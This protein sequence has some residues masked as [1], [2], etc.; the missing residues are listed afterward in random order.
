MTGLCTSDRLAYKNRAFSP[1]KEKEF[2][3]EKNSF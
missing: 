3:V 2:P 1:D